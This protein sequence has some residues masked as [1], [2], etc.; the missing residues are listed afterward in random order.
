LIWSCVLSPFEKRQQA[1][2]LTGDDGAFH[3]RPAN[4]VEQFLP[5]LCVA[6]IRQQR[7]EQ[8]RPTRRQPTPRRPDVQCGNVPMP[9]GLLPPRVRG[10]ALDRQI[11]FNEAFWVGKHSILPI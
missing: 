2:L 6:G 8:R 10:D 9:D 11:N 3:H 5:F 7:A 4:Q 1:N